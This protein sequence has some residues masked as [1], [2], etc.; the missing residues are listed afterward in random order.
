MLR[1]D[2]AATANAQPL[3]ALLFVNIHGY[4]LLDDHLYAPDSPLSRVARHVFLEITE[5]QTL[6]DIDDVAGRVRILRDL[7][8]R[9]VVDDLGAG[10]S[11]LTA[12]AQLAPD[13][14]KLDMSLVRDVEREPTKQSLIRSMAALC[15]E[16]GILA[17]CEG[18]ETR[19][20]RDMLI[21]LGCDLF[22]GF[23]FAR[24]GKAFPTPSALD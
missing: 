20:E 14:V 1:D 4:D 6:E 17:V 2:V 11:G 13:I 24:P 5:R 21:D 22:Q 9:I 10:Y 16:M 19:A 23:L 3:P 15:Q 8:F 7:G 18:V 12:F